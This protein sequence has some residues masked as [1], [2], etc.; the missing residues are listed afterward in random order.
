MGFAP[1]AEDLEFFSYSYNSWEDGFSVIRIPYGRDIFAFYGIVPNE[2]NEINIDDFIA[3]IAENG[4]DHYLSLLT[5]KEF[6]IVL[7]KFK[8]EYS[9]SLVE[10][11]N[12]LGMEKA[13]EA[14]SFDNIAEDDLFISII[15]HKTFIEVNEEG[16]EAAAIT[17]VGA[18]CAGDEAGFYATRPFVF[19]IRDDRTGSILFIGKV[20][21]PAVDK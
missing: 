4:F 3:Q 20:E 6:P 1:D 16:T 11:F 10:I 2:E 18:D 9:K 12:E 15:S 21:N 14:G 13:F 17:D 5:K 19:V 8:F 7:P